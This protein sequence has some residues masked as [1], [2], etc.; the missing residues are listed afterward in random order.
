[1]SNEEHSEIRVAVACGGTGGHVF[2]GL[3][4]ARRLTEKECRVTLWL[5]GRDLEQSAVSA[6]SGAVVTVPA[7][8]FPAGFSLRFFRSLARFMKAARTCMQIMKKERPD[9]LLA[10][11]SYASAGPVAAALVLRIPVVLHEANVIPGRAIALFSRWATAIAGSFEETRYYLRKRGI[12]ITGMPLRESLRQETGMKMRHGGDRDAFSLLVMGGS[13]GAHRLNEVVSEAVGVLGR[14]DRRIR[15]T[16]LSGVADEARV[17]K[18]YTKAGVTADV[19]A[20]VDDMAPVYLASDLAVCRSGAAT[21]AEICAFGMPAL[22]VPY[23]H[24]THDHQM[25]NARAMEKKGM[26]DVIPERDL[27]VEW[28]VDYIAG[29]MDSPRRLADMSNAALKYSP[30]N[31]AEALA[32]L[33]IASQK[34]CCAGSA[35][36]VG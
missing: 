30:R 21:C 10:M 31:A 20:F 22:M 5:T 32:E 34:N 23:P 3:A 1:M 25:A 14:T 16:H 24:A 6:W 9:V 29:C 19:H 4:T 26:V 12:E 27:T 36:G 7:E 11:G 2:P 33:V 28:L 13:R 18:I 8:G 35:N 15:V 17:R